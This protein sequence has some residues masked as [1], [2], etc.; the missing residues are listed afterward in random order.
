[1][2]QPP[3]FVVTAGIDQG[4]RFECKTSVTGIG[5]DQTNN[6]CLLDTEVSRRHARFVQNDTGFRII[7]LSSANG[8]YVNGTSINE[9]ELFSGDRLQIGQTTLLFT[10]PTDHSDLADKISMI[11]R[12][13]TREPSQII[14]S[15]D[16]GQGSR[17]L[18][19]PTQAG[20]PWLT[21]A[22]TN[23]DIL[24]QTVREVSRT[25]DIRQLLSTI[26]NLIFQTVKADRG[27]VLLH[28]DS[29]NDFSPCCVQFRDG[30]DTRTTINIS[31]TII[32]HVLKTGEGVLTS[33]ALGDFSPSQSILQSGIREAICVPMQGRHNL[34]GLIYLDVNTPT[35]ASTPSHEDRLTEE[36]LKL[37][38]AIALVAAMA[39]EDTRYYKAMVQ[40]EK[41]VAV[42]Q[43]IAH[44]SHHIKNILQG[45]RGGSYLIDIGLKEHDELKMRQ[46]WH[47]VEKNQDKIYDMVMDMLSFSTERQ[48]AL[49]PSQLNTIIQDVIELTQPR[50]EKCNTAITFSPDRDLPEG[51]FDPDGIHRAI[52]NLITNAIDAVESKDR[53]KIDIS[54][55]HLPHKTPIMEVSISDNGIGIPESRLENIFTP[56][57]SDKG[58]RGTGLGLPVSKKIA[59]EHGG[60]ISVTSG[61]HEGATFVLQIPVKPT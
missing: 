19:D 56:F 3:L 59:E 46:G 31:Q 9:S 53:G 43:T 18:N 47:T 40:S 24:F 15:I 37:L 34:V 39:V 35:Q 27:C 14:H 16:H 50:A 61:D 36:H 60:S 38:I 26:L 13:E 49:V 44:L 21:Q 55:K 12:R 52:L 4:R 57:A 8:T 2:P 1:M 33:D 5:R 28:N 11:S 51:L 54:T 6:I 25:L 58:A 23:L 10:T 29:T 7:D 32:D 17:L 45:I 48:P 22:L 20:S 30:I 41:L 42:G